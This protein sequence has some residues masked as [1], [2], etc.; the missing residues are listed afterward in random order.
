MEE[1]EKRFREYDFESDEAWKLYKDNIMIP[2]GAN[3]TAI[4]NKFK[5]K[6]YQRKIDPDYVI[7]ESTPSERS[8]NSTNASTTSPPPSTSTSNTSAPRSAQA[9]PF[10]I[11]RFASLEGL[12]FGANIFLLVNVISHLLTYGSLTSHECYRRAMLAAAVTYA[13]ALYK[14]VGFPKF[15]REW[16]QRAMVND[17]SH[18]LFIT[19]VLAN[20]LP[21]TLVLIPITIY[22]FY[23]TIF[24]LRNLLQEVGTPFSRTVIGYIEKAETYWTRALL[25]AAQF[26]VMV[27]VTLLLNAFTGHVDLLL[28]LA[29]YNFLKYRYIFSSNTRLVMGLFGTKLDSVFH[30]PSCPGFLRSIWDKIRAY[31]RAAVAGL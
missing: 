28:M 26:E 14:A 22:S 3:E 6:Y 4:I 19:F 17:N 7:T 23:Q 27:S 5:Q 21:L 15:S 30:H 29:Y 10:S 9:P 13:L 24:Y 8:A 16:A 2:P 18:Y 12:W 31:L 20:S 11:A 1:S 25:F